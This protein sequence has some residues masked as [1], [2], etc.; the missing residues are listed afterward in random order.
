MAGI[1]GKFGVPLEGVKLGLM[2]PK[3]L[4]RFRVTFNNFG[5]TGST[6]EMTGSV[7]SATRPSYKQEPVELHAYNSVGYIGGKHSWET[8]EVVIRDDINNAVA[9][10]IGSQIQRQINHFEQ[11]S[12]VAGVNYKFSMKID[13]LDG[14]DNEEL[15]SW[16]LDGCFLTD[17]KY[18]E[19][20]YKESE[21]ATISITV[22]YDNAINVKGPNTNG[23]NTV[24]TDPMSNTPSPTGGATWA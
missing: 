6:R 16:F 18:P 19:G 9:A 4:Y 3:Q 22:R 24:G 5:T 14:T 7:V 1:L 12:A 8:V 15:E 17:V 10:S 21:S 13:S 11:T 20:N 23:G 2:H